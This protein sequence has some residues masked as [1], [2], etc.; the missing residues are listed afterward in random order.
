MLDQS[1]T[2]QQEVPMEMGVWGAHEWAYGDN[3]WLLWMVYEKNM[4]DAQEKKSS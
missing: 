2:T 4:D 1:R 3:T